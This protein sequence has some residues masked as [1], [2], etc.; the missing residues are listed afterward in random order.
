MSMVRAINRQVFIA[1]L[2]LVAKE[3]WKMF[4]EECGHNFSCNKKQPTP[5]PKYN[6]HTR[7][8][9]LAVI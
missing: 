8:M 5:S 9:I 2:P 4:N 1:H 7:Y 3:H 6:S